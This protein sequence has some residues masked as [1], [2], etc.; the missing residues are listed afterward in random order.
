MQKMHPHNIRH[1]KY[2][3]QILNINAVNFCFEK[4]F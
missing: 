4:L 3:A 2:K 1:A